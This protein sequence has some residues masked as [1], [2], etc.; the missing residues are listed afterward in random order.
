MCEC[1]SVS[2]NRHDSESADFVVFFLKYLFGKSIENLLCLIWGWL[3]LSKFL[4]RSLIIQLCVHV[5]VIKCNLVI[6][7][8]V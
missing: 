4:F 6:A 5:L 1:V 3:F 2:R 7:V 8:K